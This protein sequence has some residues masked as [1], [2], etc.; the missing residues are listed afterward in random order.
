MKSNVCTNYNPCLTPPGVVSVQTIDGIKG[1]ANCF[2]YVISNN[3]TYYV[4]SSHEITIIFAG[5][6]FVDNYNPAQN[7]LGLR[8]QVCYDFANNKALI[9]GPSGDY[10]VAN[11]TE[12]TQ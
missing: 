3:S 8:S 4:S 6:V 2:V 1:L 10:R 9:F 12:V 5:P 11:L 7:P